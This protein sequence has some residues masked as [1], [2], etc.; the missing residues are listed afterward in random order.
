MKKKFE[1]YISGFKTYTP[2]PEVA[3]NF[4]DEI[5]KLAGGDAEMLSVIEDFM[6]EEFYKDWHSLAV[7]VSCSLISLQSGMTHTGVDPQRVRTSLEG[8]LAIIRGRVKSWLP[9]GADDMMAAMDKPDAKAIAATYAKDCADDI[10]KCLLPWVEGM[11]KHDF[12]SVLASLYI[13]KIMH[14]L[15]TLRFDVVAVYHIISKDFESDLSRKVAAETIVT[16][17]TDH[18]GR[19]ENIAK[20]LDAMLTREPPRMAYDKLLK[21]AKARYDHLLAEGVD[22]HEA[23]S[24]AL[25]ITTLAVL[26]ARGDKSATS[27]APADADVDA[28]DIGKTFDFGSGLN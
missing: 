4:K 23:L 5:Q 20:S 10:E 6:H 26:K 21:P 8:V 9:G 16:H 13:T 17:I 14:T 12:M 7:A 18:A 22:A 27:T 24:E 28:D 1:K 15:Y 11:A 3:A 19:W 2:D 25:R